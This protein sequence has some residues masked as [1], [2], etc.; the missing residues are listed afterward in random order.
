MRRRLFNILAALSLV[1]FC[2]MILLWAGSYFVGHVLWG[3]KVLG[4]A[5]VLDRR[6][7]TVAS[8][9]GGILFHIGRIVTSDARV[10]AG[11]VTGRWMLRGK[12]DPQERGVYS[13]NESRLLGFALKSNASMQPVTA[14][15]AVRLI[16]P[17]WFFAVWPAILPL[18]WLRWRF[19]VLPRA[20]ES[21]GLCITCG[22]DLRASKDRCPECGTPIPLSPTT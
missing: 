12:Q 10:G 9:N 14:N 19:V 18:A 13:P 22:Y 7:F 15:W 11:P 5:S 20:R 2:C 1:L 17:H 16:I 8:G 6:M 21:R 3:D 4:M